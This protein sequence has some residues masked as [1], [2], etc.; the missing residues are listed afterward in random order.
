MILEDIQLGLFQRSKDKLDQSIVEISSAEEFNK[1]FSKKTFPMKLAMCF[2]KDCEEVQ[3]ILA[4]KQ[5]T[6]RCIPL[7]EKE[8]SGQC[9]FTG[10]TLSKRVLIGQS[11]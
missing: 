7:S 2:A 8:Q 10:E 6:F 1:L 4:N 3:K 9:I 11:Y 5:L